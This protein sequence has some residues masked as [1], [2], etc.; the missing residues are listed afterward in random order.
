LICE[1]LKI[2]R[3]KIAVTANRC[4]RNPSD[5]QLLAVSK[6]MDTAKIREAYECGQLFF[7]ENFLQEAQEKI[8]HLDQSISWHFIGHLQSNKTKMAARLFQ[9]I[10]TVDR[11]KVARALNKHAAAID[12]YL[13]IL[14][15]VNIGMEEQKSGVDPQ[16]AEQFLCKLGTLENLR[17]RG[18]M[19]MP[20]FLPDPEKSRPYFR[21]L[22]KMA[23]QFQEQGFFTENSPTVLSMGMTNDFT[24]AIEEG[25][26]LVRVGTAIFGERT[27]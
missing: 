20:P 12:K 10:E 14:V 18:L 13:D 11:L 5:I 9:M 22:K 2:I 1:N 19:I 3:E 23:D 8:N 25:S 24:V 6:R 26:T 27:L 17:V 7:G 15:Q 21:A 16:N 4:G